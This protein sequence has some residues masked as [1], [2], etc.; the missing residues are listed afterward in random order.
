MIETGNR[1]HARYTREINE[2]S[3]GLIYN[4]KGIP[5]S[6]IKKA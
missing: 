2:N 5:Y 6:A 4:L 1:R 3:V